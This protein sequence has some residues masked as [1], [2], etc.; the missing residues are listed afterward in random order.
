M[1]KAYWIEKNNN[2]KTLC[3][4]I[5]KTIEKTELKII[6]GNFTNKII[7]VS[8]N[9]KLEDIEYIRTGK[10]ESVKRNLEFMQSPASGKIVKA[11]EWVIKI[12]D[13]TYYLREDYAHEW[14]YIKGNTYKKIIKNSCNYIGENITEAKKN[15]VRNHINRYKND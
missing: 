14:D 11:Y 10:I 15:L 7:I 12:D 13:L 4:V 9:N 3:E 8:H 2:K 6:E 5:E 1:T